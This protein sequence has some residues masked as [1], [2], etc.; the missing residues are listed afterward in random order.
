LAD[1]GDLVQRLA[2]EIVAENPT[3][4]NFIGSS[5]EGMTNE[6]RDELLAY[7]GYCTSRDLS[8]QYLAECY[9]RVTIDTLMEQIYFRRHGQYRHATFKEVADH[10]YFDDEYMKKYMYGL[11]LTS[12]LWPNHAA[13]HNF[14]IRTFP[15]GLDGTY[16]EIGPGHG[17]YFRQAAVLGNF[18]RMT[19]VDISPTSVALT[20]DIMRHYRVETAAEIQIQEA[21]FLRFPGSGDAFSCVVMGEVLEHVE[22]PVLFLRKI[23][24]LSNRA[25]HIYVT[26]CLSAPAVDHIFLFR[27]S[28]EVEALAADSGL[29]VEDEFLAPH[30]GKTVAECEAERL[31]VNVAYVMRTR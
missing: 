28:A 20:N 22:E 14:F 24:Q 1:G 29:V 15:K 17:Y 21:D 16:L 7:I 26:T 5:V 3:H 30:A 18:S 8:L 25:T 2:E 23:R 9:N 19:G 4:R 11:A 27:T 13:M 6:S 10:V 12:F 31:P